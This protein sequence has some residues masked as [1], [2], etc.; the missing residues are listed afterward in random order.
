MNLDFSALKYIVQIPRKWFQDVNDVCFR[1]YGGWLIHIKDGDNNAKEIYVDYDEFK[2][3]VEAI[4]GSVKS[5]DGIFPDATGNVDFG[6]TASKWLVSDANGHITT[7]DDEPVLSVDGVTPDANGDV[8]FGLTGSKYVV[9]DSNGHL[10]TTTEEPVLSVD[11]ISPDNNGNVSFGLTGSKY[12][13]TDAD[14][15]LSTTTE[16]PV[17]SVDGI[18]PDN[19]GNVS[20]GLTASKWLVS[21]ANGHITTSDSDPITVSA[22][23]EGVIYNN[24]GSLLYLP[25]GT[26]NGTVAAGNHTHGNINTFGFISPQ[27]GKNGNTLVITDEFGMMTTS[28]YTLEDV[29]G[30]DDVSTILALVDAFNWVNGT[31]YLDGVVY[32]VDDVEPDV[33]GNI[34]FGLTPNSFVTTDNDGHLTTATNSPVLSVDGVTPDSSGDV[35]FGLTANSWVATDANGHLTTD[36]TVRV[37]SVDGVTPDQNGDV[38][39]GLVANK[40]LVSDGSGHITTSASDPITVSAQDTGVLFNQQGTLLYI[41]FG[42]VAGSVAVGNHTHGNINTFGFISPQSGKNAETLVVTDEF[43]MMTTSEYSLKDISGINDVPTIVAI[44]NAFDWVNGTPH[45]KGLVNSVNSIPPD[46]TGNVVVPCVYTVNHRQPDQQGNVDVGMPELDGNKWVKTDADGN[47]ITTDA[48]PVTV[49]TGAT[50]FLYNSSGTLSYIPFGPGANQ[51]AMGNHSHNTSALNNDAGFI[52][53]SYLTQNNYTTTSD[54]NTIIQSYNYTTESDVEDIVDDM[55]DGYVTLDTVQTITANKYFGPNVNSAILVASGNTAHSIQGIGK[56]LDISDSIST[57]IRSGTGYVAVDGTNSKITI[58]AHDAVNTTSDTYIS[59]ISGGNNVI[60]GLNIYAQAKDSSHNTKGALALT[61]TVAQ[62][63]FG[64]GAWFSADQTDAAIGIGAGSDSKSKF[65]AKNERTSVLN[66]NAQLILENDGA[67]LRWTPTNGGASKLATVLLTTSLDNKSQV[68]VKGELVVLD[69]PANQSIL[70]NQPTIAKTETSSRAIATCGWVATNFGIASTLTPNKWVKTND[71]GKLTTVNDTPLV[72]S[73]SNTGFVY[74]TNGTPSYISFG[75]GANQVAMGNHSHNTSAL[76]N[77][78]G[79][80]NETQV[81]D[82]IESYSYVDEADVEDIIEAHDFATQDDLEGYVTLDTVQTIT[83]NKVFATSDNNHKLEILNGSTFNHTSTN[84]TPL[85]IRGI[86]TSTMLNSLTGNTIQSSIQTNTNGNLVSTAKE[87]IIGEGKNIYLTANRTAYLRSTENN[88]VYGDV[89]ATNTYAQMRFGSGGY[90]HAGETG[91][92]IGDGASAIGIISVDNSNHTINLS[93]GGSNGSHLHMENNLVVLK[94]GADGDYTK[95]IGFDNSS[96]SVRHDTALDLL[97]MGEEG[98]IRITKGDAT[99]RLTISD[100]VTSLRHDKRVEINSLSA[101][102]GTVV[103]NTRANYAALANAPTV[104]PANTTT[105]AIATCGWTSSNFAPKGTLNA[106]KWVKTDASGKLVSTDDTPIVASTSL[107][108]FIY[109]NRGTLSYIP[110]GPGANQVAMGNH[111]HNTSA[112]NNDAGFV[113]TS[114]VRTIVQSYNYLNEAQVEDVIE[115][116][117]YATHDDLNGYVTLNTAQL[118]TAG[119]RFGPSQADSIWIGKGAV[120]NSIS[121]TTS[122]LSLYG[123]NVPV[124]ITSHSTKTSSIHVNANGSITAEAPEQLLA[125]G[126]NLLLAANSLSSIR[127]LQNNNVL[128]TVEATAQDAKMR[129]GTG[130]WI[131][132]NDNG[133]LMGDGASANGTFIIDNTNDKINL[134]EGGNTGSHFNMTSTEVVCKIGQ[135]GDY[136]KRIAFNNSSM[137]LRHDDRIDIVSAGENGT[138]VINAKANQTALLNHPTVTPTNTTT[139]AIA[140]CGWTSSNFAPKGT[141]NANK[142][143]KTDANGKIIS[144]DDT[145]VTLSTSTTGFLYN[146]SGTLSYLGFGTGVNQV[147]RGNHTHNTSTLNNDAG[148]VNAAGVNSIIDGRDFVSETDL[149]TALSDYVT[150]ASNQTI[151]GSKSFGSTWETGTQFITGAQYNRISFGRYTIMNTLNNTRLTIQASGGEKYLDF[152]PSYNEIRLH[153]N[154]RTVIESSGMSYMKGE[155]VHLAATDSVGSDLSFVSLANNQV[156][157]QCGS[158]GGN[159]LTTTNGVQIGKALDT[160]ISVA[161]EGVNIGNGAPPINLNAR[162]NETTLSNAP[163]VNSDN[164]TSKAV[165]TCGWVA[166]KFQPKPETTVTANKY[167]ITSV[168]WN[169]TQLTYVGETWNF[170]NGILKSVTPDATARVIDTPVAY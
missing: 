125:T 147:A 87:A 3:A 65:V 56:A 124:L 90:F 126:N 21:D 64:T 103:I 140:T 75:T 168:N 5:V 31:P 70:N 105:R 158:S 101:E 93:E 166:S 62:M 59:S 98:V 52:T 26:T 84:N 142:W 47:L 82:V 114:E 8:D 24:Y 19:N 54:V 7:C 153:S 41:P 127:V 83:A 159:V 66:D 46:N 16:E 170:E 23:D 100:S 121:S 102:E 22:T 25:F 120:N 116:Y 145:P 165:A 14:G 128:S 134:S 137:S 108:G 18:S 53:S 39:F 67:E 151:T 29:S 104:T 132:L 138:V 149:T 72:L 77:D 117:D 92:S 20:F 27:S 86:G 144:T 73:T 110:F 15:H 45:F 44:T 57:T 112:L 63:R 68:G 139:R 154:G 109:N 106:S 71:S 1:S 9:T 160:Y 55:L 78:A 13:V 115:S 113:N 51:V 96:M 148:F 85:N 155:G 156:K 32:S 164:T 28:E 30:I 10:S 40:W 167:V 150:L 43:G 17:L 48:D 88:T 2:Q 38:D 76:N 107:T 161:D 6:L 81:E 97:T 131:T 169:G 95:R 118:I 130:G 123:D 99:K 42:T 152:N 129:F 12:V 157:M 141:L 91:A 79:F 11:G 135:D 162:A 163:T 49:D 69:A 50:G 74:N 146:T 37:L 4:G 119:K 34:D 60:Q 136:T 122:P 35:D 89:I 143:V 80:L 36:S 33:N 61:G 94:I 111:S 133:V 58:N